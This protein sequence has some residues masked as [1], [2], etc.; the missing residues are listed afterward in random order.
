MTKNDLTNNKFYFN[1]PN[2]ITF[3]INNNNKQ[4]D[5]LFKNKQFNILQYID[6]SNNPLEITPD[7]GS[8]GT[9]RLTYIDISYTA[10]NRLSSNNFN[11]LIYLEFLK[12]INCK[13]KIIEIDSFRDLINLK[14]LHM[15]NT[16][17]NLYQIDRIA[18]KL[19]NI[20]KLFGIVFNLCCLIWNFHGT[21]II[22]TPSTNYFNTCSDMISSIFIE[23]VFWIIG[24]CGFVGNLLSIGLISLTAGSSKS[25]KLVLS[26]SDLLTSVYILS[27]SIANVIFK[28]EY[29][30]NDIEWRESGICQLLGTLLTFSVVLSSVSLLLMTIERHEAIAKP[31]KPSILVM[32][33]F[34]FIMGISTISL[35]IST[36]PIMINQVGDMFKS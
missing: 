32:Y 17:L 30:E 35:L 7:F 27:I 4:N 15:N 21:K 34:S 24:I 13:I 9:L 28:G 11:G 26:V 36:I 19:Q 16:E 22:C 33:P 2:L 14:E 10:I 12:I 23:I 6:L 3:I 29:M 25:F 5:E 31:M 8:L 18:P 20:Q 1:F